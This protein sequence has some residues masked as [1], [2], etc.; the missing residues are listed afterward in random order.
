M[1]SKVV[2]K[3]Y[4]FW[5]LLAT[6]A[7]ILFFRLSATPIYI[8]DEAKN[9]QCAREMMQ[10]GN[11][12]VP[13][14]NGE[15]RT[16]KP[17]LH[18]LFMIASYS[19][20]GVNPFAARLF[21]AVAGILVLLLLYM[22][23]KRALGEES[24]IA[25]MAVLVLSSHFLFEFRLSVPDPYL[26]L[27]TAIATFAGFFW[28]EHGKAKDLYIT[29]FA[30]GLTF[31]SKGPV[32]VA[33]FGLSALIW[34]VWKR[35]WSRFKIADT[36]LAVAIFVLIATPWYILAHIYTD[37]EW[38]KGFF[39]DHNIN[40]FVD[41][42]EGHGGVYFLSILFFILGMF[43]VISFSGAFFGKGELIKR[44]KKRLLPPLV[45]YSLL[46][47]AVWLLF[48]SFSGTQLPN[49]IMPCYPFAAVVIGY[50]VKEL[51][52]KGYSRRYP[53]YIVAFV[54]ILIS[55]GGYFGTMSRVEIDDVRWMLLTLAIPPV[56]LLIYLVVK[57]RSQVHDFVA[58][59]VFYSL[60]NIIGL[61]SVYPGLYSVNPVANTVGSILDSPKV[62]SYRRFNPGYNFYL[63]DNI[64][65][66]DSIDSVAGIVKR[67]PGTVV[68]SRIE[69]SDS[70]EMAGLRV[71]AAHRDI[72]ENPTTIIAVE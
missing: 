72:F 12:A 65:V 15:L 44:I 11:F 30:L 22:Y 55:I 21:S 32:S 35:R 48:F 47:V 24:A 38:T 23:V 10:S 5:I 70:L 58:L 1:E 60:F 31:L 26:I 61:H 13:T 25:S 2:N 27:F 40:R 41:T 52:N 18:Y 51:F 59:F 64:K 46:V 68:I 14:F 54:A 3:K 28:M 43:P 45:E 20:F 63:K 33:L 4:I 62:I 8:L 50:M 66:Y 56:L 37:G 16:D 53:Y 39:L 29:A 17:P 69:Y 7:F 9:A 19:I 67:T 36:V 49:Y 71:V 34:M 57:R 42:K 6:A